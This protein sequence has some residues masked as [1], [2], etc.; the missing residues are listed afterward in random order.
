MLT[1]L[2]VIHADNAYTLAH[3]AA[4]EHWRR[5]SVKNLAYLLAQPSASPRQ[6]PCRYCGRT[7]Q[8]MGHKT[9]DGCGA[10]V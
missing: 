1:T 4:Q 6:T 10:T 2:A 3:N 5:E 9:C 7:A 8:K